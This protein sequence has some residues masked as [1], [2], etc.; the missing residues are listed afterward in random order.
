MVIYVNH[1]CGCIFQLI[2][3]LETQRNLEQTWLFKAGIDTADIYIRYVYSFYFSI[4]TMITIG[5]GDITPVA[6][7]EKVFLI[8]M[9]LL[10]SLL[11]AYT[12]NT[13]GG[14]FQEL[15][16]K[17]ADFNKKKYELSIYMRTR[18]IRNDIQVRVMKYIDH[19]RMQENDNPNKGQK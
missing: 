18:Q 15:A 14:I 19:I 12:V 16:Q 7:S 6:I 9:A 13:I 8:F 17:E 2:S 1:V 4:I 10:G 11:F 5:Y 3:Y